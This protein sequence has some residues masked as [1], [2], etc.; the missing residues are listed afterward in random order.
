[1]TLGEIQDLLGELN[2]KK[3][4][5]F[6]S[7]NS[8]LGT[9]PGVETPIFDDPSGD[10]TLEK[11]AVEFGDGR[12]MEIIVRFTHDGNGDYEIAL[13]DGED[14]IVVGG[15]WYHNIVRGMNPQRK[16]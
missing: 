9:I 8:Q 7:L 4:D 11:I 1:M 13:R 3:V 10:A 15:G 5:S 14:R 6:A 16:A 12:P 2:G